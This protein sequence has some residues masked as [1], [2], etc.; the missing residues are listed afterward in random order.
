MLIRHT[1]VCYRGSTSKFL[2]LFCT[3]QE[4]ADNVSDNPTA[5]N[6]ISAGGDAVKTFIYISVIYLTHFK[7][8]A[9]YLQKQVQNFL[10]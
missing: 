3:C 2:D 5:Y 6:R 1:V 8:Y 9:I 4:I 7:M 10:I